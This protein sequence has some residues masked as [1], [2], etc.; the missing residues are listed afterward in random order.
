[1]TMAMA[2]G[3]NMPKSRKI[4]IFVLV[5]KPKTV[6]QVAMFFR[7][8]HFEVRRTQMK[9]R[10][11]LKSTVMKSVIMAIGMAAAMAAPGHAG[12]EQKPIV[13]IGTGGPTG[14]YFI[15]GNAICRLVHKAAAKNHGGLQCTAPATGGSVYNVKAIRAGDL[16]MGIVQSDVQQNAYM[17]TG[18]FEKHKFA[19]LRALFSIHAEPFQLVVGKDSGINSWEDLK[20]KRVNIGNPGSGTRDTFEA[21][22]LAHKVDGSYFGKVFELDSTDQ[23]KALCDG[24]IDAFG[25]TV[26][27][28]NAG[29]AQ[30][31]NQCG[32]R[33]IPLTGRLISRLVADNSYY[34]YATIPRGTYKTVTQNVKTFGVM[35]TLVTSAKEPESKVYKLVKAVFERLD[36]FRKLHPAFA[37]LKPKSMIVNGISAPLHPG[38]IKYYREKGWIE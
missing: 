25:F 30:A 34:A 37:R 27:V 20:G 8:G 15:A 21:L 19:D 22:M 1:M 9:I 16:D 17:G 24:R 36:E 28:P 10:S 6:N 14:I 31:A 4:L 3:I 32:A 33:I 35:A 38:A 11:G 2:L 18:K 7:H 23:T 26:G 5:S 12:E 13:T 29:V